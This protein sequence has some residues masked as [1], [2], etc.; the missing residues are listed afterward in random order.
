MIIGAG[1]TGLSTA[2]H[3]KDGF[4]L[5]EREKSV[6]GLCRTF[7]CKGFEMGYSGHLIHL[8]NDYTKKVIP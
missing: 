3:L 4:I 5:C 2:Y 6:G 8:H 1:L 7:N